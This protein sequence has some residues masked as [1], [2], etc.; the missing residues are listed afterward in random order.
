[1]RHSAEFAEKA[2]TSLMLSPGEPMLQLCPAG[3]V[4]ACGA[5][6]W[7]SACGA[8]TQL[9]NEENLFLVEMLVEMNRPDF[10]QGCTLNSTSN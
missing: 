6:S 7:V 9:K 2:E 5:E 4:S 3:W 10:W 8:E 1:M